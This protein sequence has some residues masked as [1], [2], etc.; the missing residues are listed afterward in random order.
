MYRIAGSRASVPPCWTNACAIEPSAAE[1]VV[2]RHVRV[3]DEDRAARPSRRKLAPPLP[4]RARTRNSRR[5]RRER[6]RYSGIRTSYEQSVEP[7]HVFGQ[8]NRLRPLERRA[9][10]AIEE[11]ESVPVDRRDVVIAE[12]GGRAAFA[13]ARDALVGIGAVTDDVARGTARGRP[14]RIRSRT[15]S[16]ASRL[17][18][19]SETIAIQ[20]A[21]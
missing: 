20:D 14:A 18:W 1:R 8:E 17:P 16:S 6:A 21:R 9:C 19:M 3:S 7:R 11:L 4:Y 5:A 12:H 15:A 2:V 10:V 13:H